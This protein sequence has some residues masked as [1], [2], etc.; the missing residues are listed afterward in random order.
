MRLFCASAAFLCRCGLSVPR[1]FCAADFLCRGFSV[2]RTFY[3]D[4]ALLDRDRIRFASP[5]YTEISAERARIL[6]LCVGQAARGSRRPRN[7][8]SQ[9]ALVCHRSQGAHEVATSTLGGMEVE[10]AVTT[11]RPVA[12]ARGC[13]LAGRDALLGNLV[14]PLRPMLRR[15]AEAIYAHQRVRSPQRSRA[16]ARRA[17][18][19]L[20]PDI[21]ERGPTR[22]PLG[23]PTN[24]SRAPV[25]D[26]SG[27]IFGVLWRSAQASTGR[28]LT[29]RLGAT[30]GVASGAGA[31]EGEDG[32]D[33]P[34]K[35]RRE[36]NRQGKHVQRWPQH[37]RQRRQH[38]RR[39]P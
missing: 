39:R 7:A 34:A 1:I 13:N 2:L 23:A 10:P 30:S 29:A 37:V 17:G 19:C 9:L 31:P 36:I 3:T 18:I 24:P 27:V 35:S 28:H 12:G 20:G 33:G 32:G 6:V 38:V 5:R 22:A 8:G 25:R 21:S 11:C 15:I 14:S 26:G 16:L 4:A